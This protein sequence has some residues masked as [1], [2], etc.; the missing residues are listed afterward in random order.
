MIYNKPLK[1]KDICEQM[2]DDILPSKSTN[3]K[4][5]LKR[6]E[7]NYEIEKIGTYYFIKRE[8]TDEEKYIKAN[9]NSFKEII[10][11]LLMW[12]LNESEDYIVYLSYDDLFGILKM[13][14]NSYHQARINKSD[15]VDSFDLK[16]IKTKEET[17]LYG[18]N[19]IYRYLSIF[20]DSSEK[21]MKDS[22]NYVF[23]DM[24]NKNMIL[25][26]SGFKLYTK[27]RI[28][29]T[30]GKIKYIWDTKI[31]T[32]NENSEIMTIQDSILKEYGMIKNT[33]YYIID[34]KTQNE[35]KEKMINKV[36]EKFH[37]DSYSKVLI[38]NLAKE[39][40]AKDCKDEYIN[41]DFILSNKCMVNKLL[42]S[43]CKEM[44]LLPDTLKEN[45]VNKYN[46]I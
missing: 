35:I 8:L 31:C 45:F 2:N 7:N 21:I 11:R 16:N 17:E 6:W 20:F 44:L 28:E 34:K 36:C 29:E 37:C 25:L 3:R 39:V 18:K 1:Y 43:K 38:L 27:K 9:E 24:V 5:Q 42:T 40:I 41:L 33:Q 10:E 32:P 15:E 46:K 14:N 26:N 30:N 19:I 4:Y 22:L 13:V 23:K 12:Y